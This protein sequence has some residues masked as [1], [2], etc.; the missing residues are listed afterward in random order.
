M[1]SK[2]I[3]TNVLIRFFTESPLETSQKF[4]GVFSFFE[5]V[6]E[7]KI[8]V[9][10][11]ELVAFEAFFVLTRIYKVPPAQ[12]AEKLA[13]LISFKGINMRDKPLILSCFHLL[14]TKH[15]DLVDAYLIAYSKRKDI[16]SIYSYDSDFSKQGLQLL[17]IE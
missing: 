15:I 17:E 6:E 10:L 1:K 7:G 4:K 13:E 12:A 5:K 11:A 9:E 16:D 3:D 8:N 14:Q 2:L